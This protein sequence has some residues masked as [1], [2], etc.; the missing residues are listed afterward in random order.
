MQA[1]LGKGQEKKQNNNNKKLTG[2]A[3]K[4]RGSR[5]QDKDTDEHTNK[6]DTTR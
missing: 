1:S 6:A 3:T 5:G 4:T 2:N